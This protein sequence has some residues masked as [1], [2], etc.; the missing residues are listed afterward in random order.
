MSMIAGDFGELRIE[1]EMI[2]VTSSLPKPDP[3]WT[4]TDQHGHQH[5]YE[6]GYPT[7]MRVVDETYVDEFGD[8]VEDWHFECP[9]CGEHITPG[10]VGPSMFREFAPGRTAYYL[11]DEPITEE[12]F[13]EI[14]EQYGGQA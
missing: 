10:M 2:D 9:Q 4:Y 13:R 12:R 7:L 3:N 8:E 6:D 1:T 11:N 14:A 5:R